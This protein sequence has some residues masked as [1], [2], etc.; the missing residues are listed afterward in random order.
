MIDLVS[1]DFWPIV[2]LVPHWGISHFIWRFMDPHG[3]ARSSSLTGRSLRCGHDRYLIMI[4]LWSILGAIQLG[5]HLSVL[6]CHHASPSGRYVLD[7]WAWF[8][9]GFGWSGLHVWWEMVSCHL[10]FWP[11]THPMPCWGIFPFQRRFADL[12]GDYMFDDRWF[13]V[14]R[15][16]TWHTFDAIL[17]VYF[18]FEGDLRIFTEVTCA[19]IEDFTSFVLRTCCAPDA[20]LGHIFHFIWDLWFFT[21]SRVRW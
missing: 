5:P 7:L 15:S 19:T 3:L 2:P 16:P 14:V 17:G 11:I 8:N 12:H 9:Y 10:F 13:H 1:P 6:R 4:P 21:V 18:R 20:T